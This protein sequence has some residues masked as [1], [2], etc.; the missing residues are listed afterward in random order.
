MRDLQGG[1][2]F[3]AAEFDRPTDALVRFISNHRSRL[4][5]EPIC[6]VLTQ[7]G[8]QIAP[9][10]YF[11]ATRRLPSAR[12]RRDELPKAAISRV[13]RDRYERAGLDQEP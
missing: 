5:V 12:A 9:S 1:V 2:G 10:I 4:G 3:F 11:G 7:H 6:C 8:C 13:H